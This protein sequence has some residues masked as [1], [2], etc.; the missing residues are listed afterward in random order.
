MNQPTAAQSAESLLRED[1]ELAVVVANLADQL[2][3]ARERRKVVRAALEGVRLGQA[4]A[5]EIA[6]AAQAQ[7]AAETVDAE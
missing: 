3:V 5:G 6:Q 1:A 2:E 7:K 4:L